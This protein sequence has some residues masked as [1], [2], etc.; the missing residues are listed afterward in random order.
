SLSKRISFSAGINYHYYSTTIATGMKI[1]TTLATYNNMGQ[2]IRATSYYENGQSQHFTNQY[3]L[4]EV[5][6]SA[7]YQINKSKRIPLVWE[8]GLTPGYIVSSN[9][10]YYDPNTNV[11]FKNYLQPNKWQL[12]GVTAFMIGIPVNI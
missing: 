4:I 8:L 10:L 7:N 2:A 1:N 9:A 5:P 12:N 6:L 11:Y 3:H